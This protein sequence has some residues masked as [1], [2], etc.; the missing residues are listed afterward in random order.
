[1]H[2][3][4]IDRPIVPRQD[5]RDGGAIKDLLRVAR[6]EFRCLSGKDIHVRTSSVG[7]RQRLGSSYGGWTVLPAFLNAESIVYGAGVGDDISWDLSMIDRFGCTIHAFDP[8]PR[9]LRWVSSQVLPAK[10]QFHPVGLASEDGQSTFVMRNDHPDWSSYN[11]SDDIE[12]AVEIE[13]LEVRRVATLMA[14]FG[15]EH[16]DLLKMDI[17]TAEYTVIPDLLGSGIIPSQLCIEF[18]FGGVDGGTVQAFKSAISTLS[19]AGYIAFD[20][21]PYGRELSFVHRS[22]LA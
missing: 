5:I 22:M 16:I 4:Y 19:D 15:H 2:A 8:T 17:E 10:F 12:G 9:C 11:M 1:M 13:T 20:R 7:E 21:S 6:R 3:P 14:Q 18:H